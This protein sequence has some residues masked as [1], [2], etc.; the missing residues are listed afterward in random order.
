MNDMCSEYQDDRSDEIDKLKKELKT[1]IEWMI[2]N[3]MLSD[4]KKAIAEYEKMDKCNDIDIYSMKSVIAIQESEFEAAALLLL[5]AYTM[6]RHNFDILYN[7]AYVYN[8]LHDN[9]AAKRFLV[10]AFKACAGEEHRRIVY[11]MLENLGEGNSVD[12]LNLARKDNDDVIYILC[13]GGM[14]TGGPELLHQLCYKLNHLGYEVYMYYYSNPENPVHESYKI[15]RNK[16]VT[17]IINTESSIIIVPEIL[18]RYTFSM[19]AKKIII[20]WLSVDNFCKNI[21]YTSFKEDDVFDIIKKKDQN[22]R[23]LHFAQSRYAIDYLKQNGIKDNEMYYLSDYIND[24]F[25]KKSCSDKKEKYRYPNILYNPIK[26]YKFTSKII[27]ASPELNWIP[28]INY[29]PEEMR[30]LMNRSMIYIDFG[31]HPGKDRIPREAVLCGLCILTGRRGAAA[32]EVDIPIPEDYKIY[33]REENIQQIIYK[34]KEMIEKYEIEVEAF[35]EYK[36][37]IIQE[38]NKFEED[39]K[40]IFERI[41][42]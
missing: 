18:V 27:K 13:P 29:T 35:K 14:A 17:K 20:W 24:E 19:V 25:V 41:L 16:Y 12:F 36:N 7:L 40:I 11:E 15:Y 33:D 8:I 34:I 31:N 28:L 37:K 23:L 22:N 9:N 26:G 4:A 5:E 32:N 42:I 2:H 1:N 21:S 38:E 30:I 39:I 10:K 6:D 3:N